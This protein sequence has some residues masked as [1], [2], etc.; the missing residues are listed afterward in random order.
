MVTSR[1]SVDM[2]TPRWV[3][4]AVTV[5]V[6]VDMTSSPAI[7][8]GELA[9]RFGLA[10]HV[11][12]HWESVGLLAPDRGSDGRRRYRDADVYRVAIILQ[13]KELGFG[14]D[15]IQDVLQGSD[16]PA[17]HAFW[18]STWTRWSGPSR[19]RRRP[20]EPSSTRSPAPEENFLDCPEI[21]RQI[22]SRIPPP[23][24]CCPAD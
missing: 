2:T 16:R 3:A 10:T 8:I 9:G 17:R 13:A 21:R 12:R 22:A 11:L 1:A 14:L 24:G 6:H 19:Q 20:S 7:A 23:V 5:G 15:R 4:V 18:R